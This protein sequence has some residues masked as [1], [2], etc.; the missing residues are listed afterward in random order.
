MVSSFQPLSIC[1]VAEKYPIHDGVG[2]IAFAF[3][4][5]SVLRNQFPKVC[6]SIHPISSKEEEYSSSFKELGSFDEFEL[7][8]SKANITETLVIHCPVLAAPLHISHKFPFTTVWN[9]TE[10]SNPLQFQ[11]ENL[12]KTGLAKDAWGVFCDSGIYAERKRLESIGLDYDSQKLE[13]L[14]TVPLRSCLLQGQGG[15]QYDS[16]TNLF[17]AYCHSMVLILRYIIQLL[18]LD[19]LNQKNSDIVILGIQAN[20]TNVN[21][22]KEVLDPDYI[23]TKGIAHVEYIALS[24]DSSCFTTLFEFKAKT[25]GKKWR[26]VFSQPIIHSDIISLLMAS[27]P[28]VVVTGN[29]SLSEALSAG[30]IIEY[31]YRH[32]QLPLMKDLMQIA[33]KINPLA[34]KFLASSLSWPFAS[35]N[36]KIKP[37]EEFDAFIKKEH[38]L[39]RLKLLKDYDFIKNAFKK[40]SDYIYESHN[41]NRT[42]IAKVTRW[43]TSCNLYGAMKES[44]YPEVE[45]ILSSAHHC[46][47]PHLIEIIHHFDTLEGI[48]ISCKI[49]SKYIRSR[50]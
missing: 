6:V 37:K 50:L 47:L 19:H 13:T 40:I 35:Y 7:V 21:L 20:Q 48:A 45:K 31:E 49:V 26:I 39:F 10:Y 30:K 17:F 34:W 4:I 8:K 24:S 32:H 16:T 1:V 38:L 15:K 44:N 11:R 23:T 12:C 46:E 33:E 5:F 36:L 42:L 3:K 9:I 27:Q 14:Q 22:L 25:E 18:E 2:D 41:L 28:Y 29:L 43:I